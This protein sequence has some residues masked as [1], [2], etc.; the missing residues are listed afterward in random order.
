MQ[1]TKTN[2]FRKLLRSDRRMTL[3]LTV[4]EET[5]VASSAKSWQNIYVTFQYPKAC[6][7][8][9]CAGKLDQHLTLL[10]SQS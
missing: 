10:P 3:P 9:E 7:S 1:I 4:T 5:L 2:S 6:C 8:A